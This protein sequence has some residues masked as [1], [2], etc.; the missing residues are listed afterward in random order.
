MKTLYLLAALL[1]NFTT[2]LSQEAMWNAQ[3]GLGA[4]GYD[5]VSYFSGEKPVKGSRQWSSRY[6]GL[7]FYF[8]SLANKEAF[9]KAP[10]SYLPQYGGW[11]AYAMGV[12]GSLVD[13]DPE[14][15]KVHQGKLYLFYR[16]IL[17]NTLKKWN[18][19]EAEL[20]PQA[21]KNWNEQ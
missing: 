20:L 12:D 16:T 15:Y 21:D 8:A 3:G 7:V 10:E 6:K 1:L 11:C 14:A 4:H 18:A 13:V 17:N 19:R 2:G 9:E 5:L